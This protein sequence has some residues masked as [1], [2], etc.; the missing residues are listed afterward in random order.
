MK[1]QTPPEKTYI[2]VCGDKKLGEY[3]D[4]QEA[5]EEAKKCNQKISIHQCETILL[6]SP[7]VISIIT[8]S[9]RAPE[10]PS[11]PPV[12][13]PARL[14]TSREE[15]GA[16]RGVAVVFDQ[17]FKGFAEILEREIPDKDIVFHEVLGRGIRQPLRVTPR[18]YRQPARDD[19]DVLKLVEDLASKNRLVIFFT[20]DKKLANQ[21]RLV[22]GVEVVF[23]P[24]GEIAGKEMALNYMK[25]AI[26]E[27]LSRKT[28][29]TSP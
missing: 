12:A 11:L 14:L 4:L 8:S 20:G 3:K 1:P 19:Y 26:K 15:V 5:L 27:I 18:F 28:S 16:E 10:K 9:T 2:V 23:L 21:A 25:D 17:M 7:Q 24:P 22:R 6:A 29:N 13:L